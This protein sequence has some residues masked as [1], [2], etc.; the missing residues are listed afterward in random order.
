M[1]K[2]LHLLASNKYSG[3][4]NVACTIINNCT[5]R[6]DM[7]YCSPR[8]DIERTLEKMNINFCGLKKLNVTNLNKII[9]QYKP[10][11]IHAHDYKASVIAAFSSFKGKIISQLHNNDPLAKIWSLKSFLYSITIRRYQRIIGVSQLVYDEAIFKNKMLDKFIVVYN[12]VDVNEV[13]K[14]SNEECHEKEYDVFFIGRLTKQKNPIFFIKIINQ[15]KAR[16][17]DI[18]AVMIGEGEL[19]EDCIDE[20]RRLK[21]D[22]QVEMLGFLDNPFPVIKNCKVCIMPSLWEG[23]G[24]TAIESMILNKPVINSGVGGLK[25]IF[26]NKPDLVCQS[27]DDYCEKAIKYLDLQ[28]DYEDIL[29]DYTNLPRWKKFYIEAYMED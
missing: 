20:I 29:K 27:L 3:A 13:I 17:P 22:N 5:E 8:G 25:E 9:K 19:K 7:V 4:E 2:V 12:F 6:F 26:K 1:K 18:R 21:L 14:K 15:L 24:I 16:K 11:I 28:D 23:F 10:D